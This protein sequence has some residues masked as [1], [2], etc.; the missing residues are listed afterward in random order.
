M[1]PGGSGNNRWSTAADL[2]ASESRRWTG[3]VD[4]C[5]T[6]V[7]ATR[8]TPRNFTRTS[9]GRDPNMACES[10]A[11]HDAYSSLRGR[12]RIVVLAT[13][14]HRFPP[15]TD[16]SRRAFLA[17]AGAGAAAIWLTAESRDVI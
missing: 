4:C 6:S 12:I 13:V 2:N 9:D 7:A 5:A 16:V 8:N 1:A 15:M 17:A 3:G 10:A 11:R 14:S